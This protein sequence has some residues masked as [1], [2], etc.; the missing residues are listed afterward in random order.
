MILHI[1]IKTS[2]QNICSTYP[3]KKESNICSTAEKSR[4]TAGKT[5]VWGWQKPKQVFLFLILGIAASS[6]HQLKK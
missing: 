1:S 2:I 6:I 5:Y 4:N 3:V